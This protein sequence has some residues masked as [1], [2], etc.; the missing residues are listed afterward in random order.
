MD[1]WGLRASM[2]VITPTL[3][4]EPAN[5]GLFTKAKLESKTVTVVPP[6]GPLLGIV[7]L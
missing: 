5:R 3:R 6:F 2:G 1:E 7:I 4:Q